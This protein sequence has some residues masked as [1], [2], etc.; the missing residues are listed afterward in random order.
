MSTLERASQAI[1]AAPREAL[2]DALGLAAIAVI[3]FIGF[4]APAVL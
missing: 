4:L 2:A 3:V 1:A